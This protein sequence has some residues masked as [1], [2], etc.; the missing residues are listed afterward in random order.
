MKRLFFLFFVIISFNYSYSQTLKDIFLQLSNYDEISVED[1]ELMIK[2]Y[3]IDHNSEIE[4]GERNIFLYD[5]QPNN[6]FL[7]YGGKYEGINSVVFWNLSNGGQ[8]IADWSQSCGPIC[9][10]NIRF[11]IRHNSKM[12]YQEQ[13]NVLPTITI[14]DFIDIDKMINDEINVDEI[15]LSFYSYD[16]GYIL[17]EKGKNLIIESQYIELF[18]PE[19]YEEYKLGQ[20]IE[21][22][23]ND[24]TFVKQK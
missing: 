1:K 23:W 10:E 16:L 19:E 14:R 20:T 17:P 6:G 22:I 15:I 12:V 8:L 3:L 2:N 11:F 5:Y 21:L 13:F 7:S 9:D 24:G 4:I 18:F